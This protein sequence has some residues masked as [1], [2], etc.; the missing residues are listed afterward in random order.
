MIYP[1]FIVNVTFIYYTE[2]A[3]LSFLNLYR[4][5]VYASS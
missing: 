2:L 5:R 4:V 3:S 1:R